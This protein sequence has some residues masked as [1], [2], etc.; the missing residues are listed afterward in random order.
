LSW[1]S[2]CKK[3]T[4]ISKQLTKETRAKKLWNL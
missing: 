2:T 3:G 1:W 4:V